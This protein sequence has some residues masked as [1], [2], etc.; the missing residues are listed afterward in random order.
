VSSLLAC[1]NPS[2]PLMSDPA[3]AVDDPAIDMAGRHIGVYR[4]VRLLGQG[5]MGSVYLAVRD[6]EQFQKEVGQAAEAGHGY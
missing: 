6:D 3:L 4:L 1:D 2:A 5:G